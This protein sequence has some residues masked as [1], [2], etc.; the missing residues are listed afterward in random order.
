MLLLAFFRH[1]LVAHHHPH[2]NKLVMLFFIGENG[3]EKG[4]N[5]IISIHTIPV[6]KNHFCKKVDRNVKLFL[7]TFFF[8]LHRL[9]SE[10]KQEEFIHKARILIQ[11]QKYD[12]AV[13]C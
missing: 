7:S 10:S 13:S 2:S 12:E 1:L 8:T 3:P 11:L 4:H 9:L 6:S 5:L